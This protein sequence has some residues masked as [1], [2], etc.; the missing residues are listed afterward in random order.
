[1]SEWGTVPGIKPIGKAKDMMSSVSTRSLSS[2]SQVPYAKLPP[3][4]HF[5]RFSTSRLHDRDCANL[6]D[7]NDVFAVNEYGPSDIEHLEQESPT[8]H[9]LS[10]YM[11]RHS[12]GLEC[13]LLTDTASDQNTSCSPSGL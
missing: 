2:N 9:F 7:A 3:S 5:F 4:P 11:S 8:L 6:T 12:L 1:M 10:P 13:R